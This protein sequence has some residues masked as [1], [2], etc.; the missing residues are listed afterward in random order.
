MNK[1][2]LID[3][4]AA[5]AEIS[6]AAAERA[7]NATLGTIVKTVASGDTVTLLGFGA[8]RPYDRKA[9]VGKNPKTGEVLSIPAKR[10]PRFAPGTAFKLSVNKA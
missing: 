4:I 7:L 1:V 10:L 5:T 3:E 9:R 2:D 6:K 8:F